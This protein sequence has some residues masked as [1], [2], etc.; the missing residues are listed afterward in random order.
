MMEQA[1]LIECPGDITGFGLPPLCWSPAITLQYIYAF[2]SHLN[3][4]FVAGFEIFFFALFDGINFLQTREA[5]ILLT[6]RVCA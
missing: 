6:L 5:V 4:I 1:G 3:C 2:T